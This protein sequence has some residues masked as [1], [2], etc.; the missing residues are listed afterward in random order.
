MRISG[1]SYMDDTLPS[2]SDTKLSLAEVLPF[3]QTII[4]EIS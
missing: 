2:Y 3:I 1:A 4:K